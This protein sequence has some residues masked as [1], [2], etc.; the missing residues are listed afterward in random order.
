VKTLYL[1]LLII[2]AACFAVA[3]AGGTIH[4]RINLMALGLLAWIL[5]PLIE[6]TQTTT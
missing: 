2:G 3:A 5:V 4:P 6:L 1:I